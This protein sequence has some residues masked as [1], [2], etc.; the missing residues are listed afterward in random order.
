M[1]DCVVLGNL[2]VPGGLILNH[3]VLIGNVTVGGTATILARDTRFQ[4]NLTLTS[5]VSSLFDEGCCCTGTLTG[6]GIPTFQ[7]SVTLVPDNKWVQGQRQHN[8]AATVG[9]PRG[10]VCTTTGVNG[11]FVF[12]AE[13]VL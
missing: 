3:C 5:A 4:G 13:A 2:S 8:L 10:W 11:G 1:T 9:Q 7:P 6:F 12:T